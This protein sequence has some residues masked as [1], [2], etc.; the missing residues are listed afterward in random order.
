MPS[1]TARALVLTM[2][3]PA[4]IGPELALQAWRERRNDV[5]AFALVADPDHMASLARLLGWDVPIEVLSSATDAG[6]VF[7]HA[8]P[9]VAIRLHDRAVAGQL[10]PANARTVIAS[11]DAGVA[12]V[13]ANQA[14]ALVTNPI[15]KS[16]LLGA[17]FAHAGHTE[18][19]AAVA[20]VERPVMLLACHDLKVVPVTVHKPLKEAISSLSTDLIVATARTLVAAL[21]SDFGIEQPRLAVAGLN[22]HA[23]ESGALG[24][25]E[26]RLIRPAI[27]MLRLDGIDVRGPEPS[28]TMFYRA[29]RERYDA[30][31]C[32][33][34][35][36]ALIPIKTLDFDRAVNIT[37][38]LPFIRTSP[39]H[40]T[41]LDIAGR[42][43][44][45]ATSLI[46]ALRLARAI[47]NRRAGNG[48]ERAVS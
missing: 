42:G 35:D 32:M 14:A 43:V 8:L 31:L 48:D 40:G 19:L 1:A 33:Y 16:I 44:A 17:G 22:P 29:A 27:A 41:A 4:G 28:D 30:A 6:A 7:P 2:G 45:S 24:S 34:H 11:I 5:P 47:A 39:D 25:E 21:R 26:E 18:Y 36:Q 46:A 38:G 10:N 9:I 37:L 3:E 23:G 13:R 20:G 15:Q 12:A